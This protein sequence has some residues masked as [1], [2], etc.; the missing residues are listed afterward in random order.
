[1]LEGY[2]RGSRFSGPGA[3][4]LLWRFQ[5][6]ANIKGFPSIV[7]VSCSQEKTIRDY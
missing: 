3:I 7:D 5:Q 2:V 4:Q 6:L 1:M